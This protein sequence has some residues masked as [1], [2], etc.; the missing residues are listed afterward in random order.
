MKILHIC[1]ASLSYTD[2]WSYQDNLL[3][4]YHQAMGNDVVIVTS[5]W[6]RNDSGMLIKGKSGSYVNENNCLVYRLKIYVGAKTSARLKKYVGLRE[7]LENESP[8][9][10]FIHGCQLLDI[11]TI[12]KYLKHNLQTKVF[13]DNHADFSNS[14]SNWLSRNILHKIIWRHCARLIEPY[15]KKFYGV[16]PARV[17]FLADMYQIPRNKIELL[18]MGA[19]D[20]LVEAARQS[21]IRQSIRDKYNSEENDFLIMTGG[22]IDPAKKQTILL[23]KA[24]KRINRK[25]VK[26]IVF[27]S[28]TPDLKTAVESLCD[29]KTVQ[30][31][32]WIQS[33][34]SY[35]HFA[36][37]DLVVFPG[38]HSV[39]WEQVVG[40][41][42]PL[43]VKYWEGTTHVD[44]GGNCDF[45]YEDSVD[46]IQRKIQNLIDNRSKYEEM[47]RAALE[48]GMDVF[49]YRSIAQRS[50]R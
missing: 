1:L 33:D 37:A 46:E 34:E 44:V 24:V 36:A 10:V 27:G 40:L 2:G 28:V 25:D 15:T 5:Q 43:M 18:V 17:E 32:G 19:D 48:R 6:H 31:I 45:L 22:K 50:I 47:K 16:L 26:L 38:R 14:A 42:I 12:V 30:Y 49:S 39:F 4:K 3:T 11:R 29:G 13:V 21:Q 41:G 8:D 9:I 23:M 35:A 7:V 20:E